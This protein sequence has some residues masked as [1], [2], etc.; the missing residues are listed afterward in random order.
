MIIEPAAY[1]GLWPA[2][3]VR[4]VSDI[5]TPLG[6]RFKFD[7]Y[8][9]TE[10]VLKAWCAWDASAQNPNLGFDLW[11]HHDDVAKVGSKIVEIFPERKFDSASNS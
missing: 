4:K 7:Q 11:I 3:D 2:K 1:F 5:L 8:E 9:T 6:V 10:E